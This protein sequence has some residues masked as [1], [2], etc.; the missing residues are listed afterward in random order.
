[1]RV[2]L[3]DVFGGKKEGCFVRDRRIAAVRIHDTLVLL[4]GTGRI[5]AG[6]TKGTGTLWRTYCCS[7][8]AS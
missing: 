5:T 4:L 1:M 7:P 3:L 2:V 6:H 8:G